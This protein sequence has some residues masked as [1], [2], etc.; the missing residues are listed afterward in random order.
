MPDSGAIRWPLV[1]EITIDAIK[2]RR[3]HLRSRLSNNRD[4]KPGPTNELLAVR[5]DSALGTGPLLEKDTSPIQ[6]VRSHH[7]K[8]FIRREVVLLLLGGNSCV[9]LLARPAVEA[10]YPPRTA[11]QA[12]SGTRRPR[13]DRALSS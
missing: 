5:G 4:R 10:S 13:P 2:S 12:S 3:A 8:L 1:K 11:G 7:S 9:P 6:E